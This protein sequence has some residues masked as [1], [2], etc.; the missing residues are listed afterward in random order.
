MAR[1]QNADS[2]VGGSDIAPQVELIPI[3]ASQMAGSEIDQGFWSRYARQNLRQQ[4][5]RYVLLFLLF[6]CPSIIAI[7]YYAVFAADR[8]ATE[9]QFVVRSPS[10][11]NFD[12]I[13]SM[14]QNSSATRAPDEASAVHEF[15]KSRDALALLETKAN[16]RSIFERSG[17]DIFWRYP[18]LFS[19][20]LNE[21]LFAH[22]LRFIKVSS[23]SSTGISTLVVNAFRPDDATMIAN[24]LL[25][26]AEALINRL[27]ER[28]RGDTVRTAA[29]E[30]E[31]AKAKAFEAREQL[32][33]FRTRIGQVDPGKTSAAL[34]ETIGK[35]SFEV[36]QANAQLSEALRSAPQAPQVANL[37]NRIQALETQ[38]SRE[39]QQIGGTA[40]AL[41]PLIAD[42]ERL[43]LEREFADRSL[44]S[45]LASL[46]AAR[47]EAQ[48]QQ[49]YLERIVEPRSSDYPSEPRRVMWSLIA[50]AL[51]FA[52]YSIFAALLNNIREHRPL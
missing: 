47:S 52:L 44:A 36:A 39:K 15:I 16:L 48:R 35:L 4:S 50:I 3:R 21:K 1:M 10:R 43:I 28:A 37:R 2:Y 34:L 32:T 46:E 42:Y 40:Q 5:A 17:A 8:Y 13:T 25:A 18:G 31:A 7:T 23:D 29:H 9:A 24:V 20:D 27:N 26:G 30:V 41:A 12:Q 51:S 22:Y 19:S 11:A 38:I 14:I 45:A 49:L 6:V 33:V